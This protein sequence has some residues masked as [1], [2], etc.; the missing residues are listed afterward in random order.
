[1]SHKFES[2][3]FFG[4]RAWHGL[5]TT[6][7]ENHEARKSVDESI[8]LAGLDWEVEKVDLFAKADADVMPYVKAPSHQ[9]VV[10][11][12]DKSILGV[13]GNRYQCLQNREQFQWFQPFLDSGECVFETCGSLKGGAL[14]WVLAKLCRD[15]IDVGG[16]DTV[17]KYLLLSSSHDGSQATQ[18]G[19]N[20]I[21]VVCWN[22]L[23][24]ALRSGGKSMLKIRHTANQGNALA[25]VRKTINL[26]DQS[27]E[28]TAV[29]YR[30]L[31]AAGVNKSDLRKYV[32]IVLEL[33]EDEKAISTRQK[34]IVDEIVK[35]CVS[36][37]GN[38]GKSAWS[39]YNG[40]TQYVTHNYGRTAEN[41]LRAAW[42]G[43]GRKLIDRGLE[44][45]L[46]LAS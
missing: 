9:A 28:A 17:R 40:L 46:Q 19:F 44:V 6:L 10:R 20:P 35:L 7:P 32:K 13:V 26:I 16:G 38:D 12:S 33:P 24:A 29:Q 27:F 18:V 43:E 23:S 30:R 5:G 3:L 8:K 31:A 45:A 21:R 4:E 39:A 22:T 34:N 42:Y 25:E 37:V 11:T 14:V 36:G 15:D 1:M 2:G 41:R